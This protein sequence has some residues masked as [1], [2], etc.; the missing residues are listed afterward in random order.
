V[1]LTTLPV[2]QF[3]TGPDEKTAQPF[4]MQAIRRSAL[5]LHRCTK[6]NTDKMSCEAEFSELAGVLEGENPFNLDFQKFGFVDV[7]IKEELLMLRRRS[8][9]AD[10]L[11]GRVIGWS[12]WSQ[13]EKPR[14]DAHIKYGQY[15]NYHYF[16]VEGRR[17]AKTC[18]LVIL[19]PI[20][21]LKRLYSALLDAEKTRQLWM[22]DHE[23]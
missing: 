19:L 2:L 5:Q 14:T 16:D 17:F 23:W 22:I 12:A 1:V 4:A 18:L 7:F 6:L 21:D 10:D 8:C 9:A 13:T 15:T 3:S 20:R 11:A